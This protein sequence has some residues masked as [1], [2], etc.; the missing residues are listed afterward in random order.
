MRGEDE[1]TTTKCICQQPIPPAPSRKHH[2]RRRAR[3]DRS[4]PDERKLGGLTVT[5]CPKC[6]DM[7]DHLSA[8]HALRVQIE[9]ERL[10]TARQAMRLLEENLRLRE[11]L[12]D[13][14]CGNHSGS[15]KQHAHAARTFK[16]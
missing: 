10:E 4:H 2:G 11:A 7:R 12:D 14:V 6:L 1:T 15:P 16:P 9:R 8:E 5:D 13:I 3:V